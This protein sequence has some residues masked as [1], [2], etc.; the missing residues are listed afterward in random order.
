MAGRPSGPKTR[1]SGQWTE[2]RFNSFIKS[3]LRGASRKWEPMQRCLK[4]ARTRRGYYRCAGCDEE[5]PAS[6]RIGNKKYK[7]AIAD[8]IDPVIDPRKGHTT[9]DE[10]IERMFVEID[11]FQC[12]C[13]ACHDEKCQEERDITKARRAKEKANE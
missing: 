12:L 1:C 5:V 6:I 7:N 10:C 11:G 2:A 13:K 8:H 4:E 3:A 9:W